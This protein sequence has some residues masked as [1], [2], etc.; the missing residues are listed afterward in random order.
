MTFFPIGLAAQGG[1]LITPGRVV[2]DGQKRM[3]ELNLANAGKDTARYLI[4]FIEIKMNGDGTFEQ[5]T[6]PEP[7]QYFASNNL[8]F[9]PRSIKLAPNESQVVK[10]QLVKNSQLA[11]GEYR[12]HMYFR[13]VPEEVPLGEKT[14][15]KDPSGISVQLKP[16]FGISIPVIIR[17]GENKADVSISGVALAWGE[18]LQPILSMVLNRT[19]N[20][21]VYG[22]L[23]IDLISPKGK[24]TQVGDIKGIAVY[25]PISS[26]SMRVMLNKIAGVDYK[27]GKLHITYTTPS[28]G[29]SVKTIETEL[30]LF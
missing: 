27:T 12:S 3:Q 28:T 21:S 30:M 19:G 20:M 9:F 13:A 2:F 1:L 17:V 6:Q 25:T 26:R 8:R 15:G 4:S 7:G 23:K 5:I 29:G 11:P 24:I 14:P 10:L 18:D 22:D 16:I